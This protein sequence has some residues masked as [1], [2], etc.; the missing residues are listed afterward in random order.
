MGLVQEEI[1]KK[2]LF[3]K[4]CFFFKLSAKKGLCL[5]LNTKFLVDFRIIVLVQEKIQKKNCL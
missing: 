2:K 3:V 4:K 5:L 1:R